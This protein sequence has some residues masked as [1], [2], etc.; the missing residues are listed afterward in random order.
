M[1]FDI[2]PVSSPQDDYLKNI[3]LR[4]GK[5][6]AKITECRFLISLQIVNYVENYLIQKYV[7]NK[8]FFNKMQR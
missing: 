8:I 4:T 5:E 7:F 6:M 3:K 1:I 2:H